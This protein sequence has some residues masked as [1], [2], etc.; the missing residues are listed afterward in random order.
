MPVASPQRNRQMSALRFLQIFGLT[1]GILTLMGLAIL[2]MQDTRTSSTLAVG[3]MPKFTLLLAGRDVVYCY[4][5]QRCKNQDQRE[6]LYQTPNTDTVMLVKINETGVH[7]LNIPRDTNVGEYNPEIGIAQQKINSQYFSGGPEALVEAAEVITGERIDSYVIVRTDYVERVID[8]LGGLDVNVSEK[9]GQGKGIDWVDKAA[10]IDFKL[11]PGTHHLDGKDGLL[12]LRVRKGMGD[13]YGRI[14]R[15]KQALAQLAAKLKTP[16]GLTAL[17]TILGGVG[18]GVETNI[19]PNLFAALQPHL[20]KLKLEFATLPTIELP[21]ISNLMVD[22][23]KL[24]EVWGNVPGEAS[25]AETEDVLADLKINVYDASGTELGLRLVKAL[26][27]LGVK[28]IERSTLPESGEASQ[29]FTRRNIRAANQL[30]ALLQLPRLQGE[31]FS[32]RRNEVGILLGSDSNQ[33]LS[34]LKI[35]YP[36]ID[37]SQETPETP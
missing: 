13:D 24:A 9:V 31:R 5:R 11:P 16:Q 35:A 20:S 2:N 17:P 30:S 26:N 27:K 33:L 3:E 32:V 12:Y 23:E 7:V 29:V 15:Q 21:K 8:A 36:N 4:Y 14:D 1:L 10:G 6:G 28:E 25:L 37:F 19:D 22:Y 18:N 34:A